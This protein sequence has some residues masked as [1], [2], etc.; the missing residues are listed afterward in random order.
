MGL[1]KKKKSTDEKFEDEKR[2]KAA[3]F[4]IRMYRHEKLNL[5]PTK[6]SRI[7]LAE[8]DK[9]DPDHK[10][11][12]RELVELLFQSEEVINAVTSAFNEDNIVSDDV[13]REY[14][15]KYYSLLRSVLSSPDPGVYD[16]Y[17]YQSQ[18][19]ISVLSSTKLDVFRTY[20]KSKMDS[21]PDCPYFVKKILNMLQ[22]PVSPP[23]EKDEKTAEEIMKL[24]CPDLEKHSPDVLRALVDSLKWRGGAELLKTL[25][26]VKR[27]PP[28][29]R[30]IRG[31]ESCVFIETEETVHYI[32]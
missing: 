25:E 7:L 27:T 23:T 1:F 19:L 24:V 30:H 16:A 15:D 13:I 18:Q 20:L 4:V 9:I 8:C 3:V 17:E 2:T 5:P 28:E 11:S 22:S 31:R 10:L 29:K 14:I 12:E 6:F 26:Q 32:G 21:D